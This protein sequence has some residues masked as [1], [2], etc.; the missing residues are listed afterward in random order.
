MCGIRL[1]LSCELVDCPILAKSGIFFHFGC[2]G[3]LKLDFCLAAGR[4]V[5]TYVKPEFSLQSDSYRLFCVA[6]CVSVFRIKQ[7]VSEAAVQNVNSCVQ[8]CNLTRSPDG[9]KLNLLHECITSLNSRV[10]GQ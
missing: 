2:S 7:K 6:D 1:E 5:C 10:Q 8:K 3:L 9:F 4:S